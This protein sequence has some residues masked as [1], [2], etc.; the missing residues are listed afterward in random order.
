MR[1]VPYAAPDHHAFVLFEEM[2][3]LPS[4]I[5]FIPPFF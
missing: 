1:S 3:Y 4:S 2:V 5:C